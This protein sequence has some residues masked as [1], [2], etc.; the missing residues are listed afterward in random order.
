M[1]V[2]AVARMVVGAWV[3]SKFSVTLFTAELS[4]DVRWCCA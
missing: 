4:G 1:I 2:S 3:A